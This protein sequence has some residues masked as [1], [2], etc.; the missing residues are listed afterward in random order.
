MTR[1]REKRITM[2]RSI[3]GH[4]RLSCCLLAVT[5]LV[6]APDRLS[7]QTGK[8]L[9]VS[10][11]EGYHT[12]RIPALLST[13]RGSILASAKVDVGEVVTAGTSTCLLSDQPIRATRGAHSRWSGTTMTTHVAIPAR[14]LIVKQV[15]FGCS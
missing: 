11:Q 2:C 14:W 5:T 3:I 7:A 15:S 6:F 13:P 8:A 1:S 4:A 12:Y 10:G 9:F